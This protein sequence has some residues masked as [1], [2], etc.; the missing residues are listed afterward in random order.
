MRKLTALL[1]VVVAITGCDK[2]E[3][4][5]GNGPVGRYQIA[6]SSQPD[7]A[8]GT[9]ILDTRNGT[10]WR[11]SEKE[12]TFLPIPVLSRENRIA[13][14]KRQIAERKALLA[15]RGLVTSPEDLEKSG[16]SPEEKIALLKAL[17]AEIAVEKQKKGL[18]PSPEELQALKEMTAND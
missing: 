2:L 8:A 12:N 3:T 1:A 17:R 18:S 7:G 13:E 11:L 14:L 16:K 5:L 9:F 10:A 4:T 6:T 15:Q